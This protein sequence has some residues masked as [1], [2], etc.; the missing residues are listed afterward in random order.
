MH[1]SSMPSFPA[2]CIL[3]DRPF[4]ETHVA[5]YEGMYLDRLTWRNCIQ[6]T[7]EKVRKNSVLKRLAGRKW[8]S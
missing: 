2:G 7:V 6:K 4:V 5:K 8:D 1:I 3:T